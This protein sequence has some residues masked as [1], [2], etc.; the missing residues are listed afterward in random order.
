MLASL[1]LASTLALTIEGG[2]CLAASA[3]DAFALMLASACSC[4]LRCS[5]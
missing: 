2:Q 1:L 4:W 5:L 3:F